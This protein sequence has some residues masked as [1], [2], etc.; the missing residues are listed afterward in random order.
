MGAIALLVDLGFGLLWTYMQ[1][2]L[3]YR[4]F[5]CGSVVWCSGDPH[6][7]G[8]ALVRCIHTESRTG[9]CERRRMWTLSL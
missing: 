1:Q 2:L 9:H 6:A 8:S 4:S 7:E 5:E 3:H